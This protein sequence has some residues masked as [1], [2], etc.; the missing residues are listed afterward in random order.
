MYNLCT[1]H[2]TGVSED[3]VTRT[4]YKHV[5]EV[6]S[7]EQVLSETLMQRCHLERVCLDREPAA[8]SPGSPA[9]AP[10]WVLLEGVRS[11]LASGLASSSRDAWQP[12]FLARRGGCV[13]ISVVAPALVFV[14]TVWKGLAFHSS[15]SQRSLV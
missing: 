8:L 12:P 3:G 2:K 9:S 4:V 10:A 5:T 13:A 14:L 7:G 15:G 6:I 1:D 11:G